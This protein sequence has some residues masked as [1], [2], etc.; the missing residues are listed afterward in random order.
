M[1][2]VDDDKDSHGNPLH[3]ANGKP[4]Y[5]YYAKWRSTVLVW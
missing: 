5:Y 2:Y 3:D 4:L 1:S